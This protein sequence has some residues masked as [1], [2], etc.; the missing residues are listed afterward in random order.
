[1]TTTQSTRDELRSILLGYRA[2]LSQ[3][4]NELATGKSAEEFYGEK[5][6][7]LFASYL[8]THIT[9]LLREVIGENQAEWHDPGC[10]AYKG[11]D[12]CYCIGKTEMYANN[13]REKQRTRAKEKGYDL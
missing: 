13:L 10:Y 5:L 1:M 3:G 7:Q 2:E 11:I 6:E 12:Y 4:L 9:E 8:H